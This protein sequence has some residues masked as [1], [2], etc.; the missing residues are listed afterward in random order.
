MIQSSC[1]YSPTGPTAGNIISNYADGITILCHLLRSIEGNARTPVFRSDS[2]I[3]KNIPSSQEIHQ[4]C[5]SFMSQ[6]EHSNGAS[7]N[8][9]LRLKA[10]RNTCLIDLSDR[11]HFFSTL[12]ELFLVKQ[13]GSRH[14]LP[15]SDQKPIQ[16]K[17]ALV[18]VLTKKQIKELQWHEHD[19]DYPYWQYTR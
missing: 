5:G 19:V 10:S 9:L 7:Q 6:L 17:S 15:Q 14:P 16:N 3:E 2:V 18:V 12:S 11:R 13:Q 8:V 4:S 1:K